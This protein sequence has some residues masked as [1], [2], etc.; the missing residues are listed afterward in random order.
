[1]DIDRHGSMSMDDLRKAA[2]ANLGRLLD[3]DAGASGV[4]EAYTLAMTLGALPGE[5]DTGVPLPVRVEGLRTLIPELPGLTEIAQMMMQRR[6]AEVE[7][8]AEAG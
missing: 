1:M 7:D 6:V 3:R 4:S 8:E 5:G 2:L